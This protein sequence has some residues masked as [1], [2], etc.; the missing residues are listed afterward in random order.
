MRT[1]PSTQ[2]TSTE[3]LNLLSLSPDEEDHGSLERII[4]HSKWKF[5]KT[6]NLFAARARL[7]QDREISVVL[8]ERDLKPGSWT[9]MLNHLQSLPHPPSLIVMSRH[10]D[11]RLWSEVLNLGGWDVLLK[12]L[13]H[14]EVLRSV[15]S[16]W[17]HWYNGIHSAPAPKKVMRAG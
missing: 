11:D 1:L 16:A 6:S 2:T 10:A 5:L 7:S 17:Q 9:D 15:R 14:T 4:A 13:N 3:T 12:P 8:C